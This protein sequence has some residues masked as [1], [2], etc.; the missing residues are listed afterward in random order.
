MLEEENLENLN[1][2]DMFDLLV[3]MAETLPICNIEDGTD[4]TIVAAQ[5]MYP[6]DNKNRPCQ[7]KI[8]AHNAAVAAYNYW[9]QKAKTVETWKYTINRRAKADT[10]LS[11]SLAPGSYCEDPRIPSLHCLMNMKRSIR[12]IFWMGIRHKFGTEL[13]PVPYRM[14]GHTNL[15]L[16]QPTVTDLNGAKMDPQGGGVHEGNHAGQG[17]TGE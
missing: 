12:Y 15:Q 11:L 10:P 5:M 2:T 7:A 14:K 4:Y 3:Q 9:I 17:A 8:A 13:V 1:W 16:P 6:I